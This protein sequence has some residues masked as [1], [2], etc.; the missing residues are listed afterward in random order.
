MV[1]QARFKSDDKKQAKVCTWICSKNGVVWNKNK[2]KKQ[3]LHQ[4]RKRDGYRE[5]TCPRVFTPYLFRATSC[6]HLTPDQ[7]T[8][9][10]PIAMDFNDLG[11]TPE[12]TPWFGVAEAASSEWAHADMHLQDLVLCSQPLQRRI[13]LTAWLQQPQPSPSK[14]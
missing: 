8:N 6:Q 7:K 13:F 3:E 5:K 9:A 14:N 10:M 2:A 1:I 4:E 12:D 11:L